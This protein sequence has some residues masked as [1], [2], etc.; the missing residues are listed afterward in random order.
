ME[1]FLNLKISLSINK[2]KV[3]SNSWFVSEQTTLIR[4]AVLGYE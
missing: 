4:L 3:K 2:N 1:V